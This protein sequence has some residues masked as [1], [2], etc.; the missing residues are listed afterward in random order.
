MKNSTMVIA[1]LAVL[2]G[3]F[4]VLNIMTSPGPGGYQE[5][6][7]RLPPGDALAGEE[8]FAALNCAECHTV[9]ESARFDTLP[10]DQNLH[11]ELGGEVHV[12]KS[13]GELV[14][15]IIHPSESIRKDEYA[16][17]VDADGNSTM[18]DLTNQMTTRQLIDLVTY[19]QE[20][21]DVVLP[22]LPD[23]Y[24]PNTYGMP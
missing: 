4:I 22:E 18:P 7:F 2:L 13:Y 1:L 10:E 17:Y 5:K 23:N 16:K 8:A 15:A 12:V 21:Y 3:L 11:V 24:Y 20:H 19:L 14:T 6:G 9:Y